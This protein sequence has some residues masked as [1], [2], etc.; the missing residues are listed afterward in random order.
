MSNNVA[1]NGLSRALIKT[2]QICDYVPFASTITNLVDIFEKCVL[3]S[4]CKPKAINENRYI[5]HIKDKSSLRCFALLVPILGNIIVGIYDLVEKHRQ[6]NNDITWLGLDSKKLPNNIFERQKI[7]DKKRQEHI[8]EATKICVLAKEVQIKSLRL[9]VDNFR[10]IINDPQPMKNC[11][12]THQEVINFVWGNIKLGFAL[13]GIGDSALGLA[14]LDKNEAIIHKQQEISKLKNELLQV[15]Q[16]SY[17]DYIQSLS[18]ENLLKEA[19]KYYLEN[20]STQEKGCIKE[21]IEKMSLEDLLPKLKEKVQVKDKDI[22]KIIE[23]QEILA[24]ATK[25]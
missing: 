15:R 10:K 25:N 7:I 21:S 6:Q 9:S 11:F 2:D 23:M 17:H 22:Y 4:C 18:K 19:Q 24:Q 20:C 14:D 5:S 16:N 12:G 1:L 13:Q 3:S 8:E